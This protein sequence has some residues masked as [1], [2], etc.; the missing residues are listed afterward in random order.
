MNKLTGPIS[1]LYSE[2]V[3]HCRLGDVCTHK[4]G[5]T[6]TKKDT[7]FGKVPVIGGGRQPAYY[8]N[9][10]NREAG[11]IAVSGSGVYAG[12]VSYWDIPVYLSDSFSLH[13]HEILNK[14]YLYYF[15]KEKQ[16]VIH[17]YK[18]GSGVPHVY[19]T[20]LMNLS[21]QIPSI[22][23]QKEI[24][25]ILD[26]FTT[27][28][29]ELKAELEARKKQYEYYRDELLTFGEE[30]E[31]KTLG[32]TLKRTRGTSITANK[33]RELH[34]ENGE[35]R[36]FAGGKTFA[37]VS[38]DDIPEKDINIE[39]SII[40]KSRGIIEFEYYNKPFSHKNEF[41]SYYSDKEEMNIKFVYYYL[42]NNT[43]YF[44]NRANIMQMPQISIPI[45]DK[46]KIPIPPLAE[47]ERI[48][49][50]L[51][52]FHILTSYITKGLPAEIE[53]RRKQYEYYRN[54]LLTFEES[55]S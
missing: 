31:W 46:Y 54:K 41:W 49:N 29:A 9:K 24:V 45:T 39:P 38:I 28:K 53:A 27:L 5:S 21:I 33:M 15:L 19:G 6:I 44:Q 18:K 20:D 3:T 2:D 12:F 48:V 35:V 22:E 42:S 50:I 25:N 7:V 8:H 17:R 30:V 34:R 36:I 23:V 26:K 55:E 10:S 14:K 51:D 4:R 32:E 43:R 40:V 16:H 13:P 37:N 47:Q 52:K 11:T 1:S